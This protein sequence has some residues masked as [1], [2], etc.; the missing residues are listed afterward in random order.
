MRARLYV[1]RFN[2]Y[3]G[4]LRGTPLKLLGATQFP[5]TLAGTAIAKPAV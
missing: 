4:A 1:D 3:C 5:N 2:L